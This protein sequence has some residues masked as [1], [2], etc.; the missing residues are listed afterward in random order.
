MSVASFENPS[1]RVTRW[2]DGYSVWTADD[3]VEAPGVRDPRATLL[4]CSISPYELRR[5]AR[6]MI[7]P[8]LPPIDPSTPA[9]ARVSIRY[10][11]DTRGT[12]KAPDS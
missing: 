7:G 11:R 12:E 2:C 6:T 8:M 5:F 9:V 10:E 3:R 4:S 1:R